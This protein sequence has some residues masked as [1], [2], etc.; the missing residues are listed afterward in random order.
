MLYMFFLCLLTIFFFYILKRQEKENFKDIIRILTSLRARQELED[1][2]EVLKEEYI[3]TLNKIIKQEL[4]LENSIVEL[5]EYR[6]ELEVTYDALVTK[7]TQLEYSNHIL[8]RRVENLS[9]LNSLSRAVL[10]IL[11]VDKIINIILDAYFV[12]TGAKRISLYLW[13]NGKLKNR[14]V[15][16]AIRFRGEISF[17]EDEIKEFTRSDY[18]RIYEDLSKGF[19]VGD[20]E[21][22][23]ISPLVVKGKELGVIYVIEDRNKLIDIDEE[24]ISALVIQVSIAINNAQIYSA[25]LVKERMSN[26]LEVAARIQKK[27]LPANINDIFGLKIAN[28]FE[29]AKEIGGDYYD[30]TVADEDNCCITIADVSGKGVPA[31][32]LMALGRSVLKTLMITA[33]MEPEKNLN[34]LNRLIYPDITEDMFITMMHSKYNRK[35]QILSY[36][37]AGHNPLVVYRAETDTVELHTVKGVA[38]GFL[39]EYSYR[40]GELKL[41]DGDIVVFY[42]DGINETENS[43]KDMF[44]IDRLKEVV[45]QNKDREPEEIKESI[46]K[47]ITDF[48]G[49]YEQVDDLTFVILKK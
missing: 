29:P 5:R 6:K 13:D 45:Y 14:R 42:T 10:S 23:V 33:D 32:F 8:E 18:K 43:N 25:L 1:I 7:S 15:K 37:N 36:S 12:L 40:H 34:E 39:K 49:D 4:E 41:N 28:F 46:L 48:R 20:D 3:E 11:E 2:P 24:T 47:A 19:A 9:N 35:T 27:I 21:V 38:I 22:I 17:S 44:G 30:Y 26:E 31:A 16:G